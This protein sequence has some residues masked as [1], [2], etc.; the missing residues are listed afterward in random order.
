MIHPEVR[1]IYS[2]AGVP[3]FDYDTSDHD[4]LLMGYHSPRRLCALAEGFVEGATAHY[5]EEVALQ[6]S[7]C[8]HRGGDKRVIELSFTKRRG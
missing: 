2:A 7:S 3:I 8:G 6:Q 1:K 5:G 4:Q